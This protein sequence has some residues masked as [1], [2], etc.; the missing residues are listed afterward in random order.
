[1]IVTK[2]V[3]LIVFLCLGVLCRFRGYVRAEVIEGLKWIIVNILLPGVLFSS[4][5]FAQINMGLLLVAL[6][7]CAANFIM[8]GLG[9]FISPAL[10][11]GRRYVQFLS[12]GMEYGMLGL[13]L[14]SSLYG[15]EAVQYISIIDLGHELFFW[16][17]LAPLFQAR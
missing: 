10:T 13:A 5:L 12:G 17:F 15:V 2:I 4:F 11:V 6:S 3:P 14:F 16:F 7:V 1:M 9:K 8:F